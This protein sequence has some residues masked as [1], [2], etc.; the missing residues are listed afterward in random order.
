MNNPIAFFA[1][2]PQDSE[3]T[4]LEKFATFLVAGSCTLAGFIW[5]VMYYVIFG[6]GLIA[7]LPV[8]FVIIVGTAMVISHVTKNQYYTIYSQIVCIIYIPTFIQWSIGGVFDS[9]LVVVWAFVGPICA[10]MFFSIKRSIP[11]FV[12]YLLNLAL[13]VIFNDFFSA[14]GQNVSLSLQLIFFFMNL[15]FASVVVFIFASYY[16]N[17]AVR[18]QKKATKLLEANLQQEMILRESEKLAT[19]GKLSAGVAH[20]LNN[21]VATSQRDAEQLQEAITKLAASKFKLGR[22]NLSAAQLEKLQLLASPGEQR[23]A[24]MDPV[25]RNDRESEIET[26]CESQG[27]HNVWEPAPVFVSTGFSKTDLEKLAQQYNKQELAAVLDFIANSHTTHNLLKDIRT[28]SGKI[29]EIVS[30]MHS[31]AFLDQGEIQKVDIHQGLDDTLLML[32]G[33]LNDSILLRRDYDRKLPTISAHGSELNQV[34]DSMS[35]ITSL[36]KNIRGKFLLIQYRARHALL[37]SCRSKINVITGVNYRRSPRL[38]PGGFA[39]L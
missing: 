14:Q 21:P 2:N 38:S 17:A 32:K 35:A 25:K 4:K 27:L 20:E 28:S 31:Y 9:G 3:E 18:E 8:I 29:T 13:T 15:G 24:D 1:Y 30:A 5:T 23:Q 26:F 19:L 22:L 36:S 6:W 12:F 39:C 34:W 33:Q 16:A 11:W 37:L 10:L 7:L